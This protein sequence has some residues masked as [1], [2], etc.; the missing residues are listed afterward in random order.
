MGIW[1]SRCYQKHSRGRPNSKIVNCCTLSSQ[2]QPVMINKNFITPIFK[3]EAKV[4]LAVVIEGFLF[5][6]LFPK[7]SKQWMPVSKN[8]IVR[9]QHGFFPVGLLLQFTFFTYFYLKN[10]EKD[11]Q[12]GA[13]YTDFSK[14][15]DWVSHAALLAKMSSLVQSSSIVSAITWWVKPKR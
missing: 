6:Q 11:M 13:I 10:F 3:K 12:I 15:F 1:S 8:F 4:T 9:F 7:C 14:A 2:L 5:N